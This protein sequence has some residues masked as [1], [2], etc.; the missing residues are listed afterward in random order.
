MTWT[1]PFLT[2]ALALG[3]QWLAQIVGGAIVGAVVGADGLANITP[4]NFEGLNQ[5]VWW[6]SGIIT[7][8]LIGYVMIHVY[9]DLTW[10][11]SGWGMP[12]GID[13]WG[14]FWRPVLIGAL[15]HGA[16]FAIMMW[17]STTN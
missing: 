3:T 6:S 8:V 15:V 1:I 13:W 10:S 14:S 4:D 7:V 12:W 11:A 2:I 16:A 9:Q 17:V 5:L